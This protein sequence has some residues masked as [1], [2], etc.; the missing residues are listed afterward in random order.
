ML[1][2][3]DANDFA[4]AEAVAGLARCALVFGV[5]QGPGVAAVGHAAS[6]C[7]DISTRR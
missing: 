3:N 1:V 2:E 4:L 7:A 6:S 5:I